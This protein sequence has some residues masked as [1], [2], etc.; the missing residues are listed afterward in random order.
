MSWRRHPGRGASDRVVAALEPSGSWL[1]TR[2]LA[3]GVS[4]ITAFGIAI[5]PSPVGQIGWWGWD[6][7]TRSELGSGIITGL[8]V[9]AS[10]YLLEGKRDQATRE[11]RSQENDQFEEEVITRIEVQL[12][13]I[14]YRLPQRCAAILHLNFDQDADYRHHDFSSI[15]EVQQLDQIGGL[16]ATVLIRQGIDETPPAV[17]DLYALAIDRLMAVSYW[18]GDQPKSETVFLNGDNHPDR[19]LSRSLEHRLEVLRTD[20]QVANQGLM[21]RG[22]KRV[23][24]V[25]E[26][27]SMI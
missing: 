16:L 14:L 19:F 18:L 21:G 10:L 22:S 5:L 11:E 12:R 4:G 7:G 3:I 8:L 15:E 13:N 9:G 2:N 1:R 17:L 23:T 25:Q 6:V 27:T 26:I 20:L 24:E